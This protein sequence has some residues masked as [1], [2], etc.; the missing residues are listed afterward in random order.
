MLTV[1]GYDVVA[2]VGAGVVDGLVFA[3]EDDG[4]LGGEAAER[5]LFWGSG[6]AGAGC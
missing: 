5:E 6:G 3:L 1:R 4:D 2:A